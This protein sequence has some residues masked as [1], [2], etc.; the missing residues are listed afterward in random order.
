MFC[1]EDFVIERR[2]KKDKIE[3][4]EGVFYRGEWL[5][6]CMDGYGILQDQNFSVYEGDFKND[7][8]HGFGTIIFKN[9]DQYVGQ[10]VKGE[11]Q[12]TGSYVTAK[13]K[14]LSGKWKGNNLV[15]PERKEL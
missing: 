15:Q 13:G 4:R 1:E 8:A 14:N 12:G 9:G 10:W 11:M 2:I 5:D 6:D 7:H 3:I